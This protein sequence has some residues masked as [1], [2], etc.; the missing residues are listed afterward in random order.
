MGTLRKQRKN[1]QRW[2]NHEQQNSFLQSFGWRWLSSFTTFLHHILEDV[3]LGHDFWKSY[4]QICKK[5]S[6]KRAAWLIAQLLINPS[7][8]GN[9]TGFSFWNLHYTIIGIDDGPFP[10]LSS[11]I[12]SIIVLLACS[13]KTFFLVNTIITMD[14]LS[15]GST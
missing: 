7:Y 2:N 14:V 9:H 3:F 11:M 6:P 13:G 1:W 5:S 15:T 8:S 10:F 12:P 4:F